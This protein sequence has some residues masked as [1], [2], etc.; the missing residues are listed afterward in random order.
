MVALLLPSYADMNE[1]ELLL[2]AAVAAGLLAV[3]L[4]FRKDSSLEGG[5]LLAAVL[6]GYAAFFFG[7]W[8]F[9][10]PPLM[11]YGEHLLVSHR[12]R[13][14]ELAQPLQSN[15]L[16]VI[17]GL[18]VGFTPSLALAA[19][20]P[21]AKML[22]FRGL[23]TAAAIHLACV[24]YTTRLFVKNQPGD[25]WTR[26]RSV[27]KAVVFVLVPGF[28]L[29]GVNLKSLAL[30][31]AAL[32]LVEL[33]LLGFRYSLGNPANYPNNRQRWLVQGGASLA[34]SMLLWP[35]DHLLRTWT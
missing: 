14:A 22:A 28:A 13:K 21:E 29:S 6:L 19:W 32:L 35:L 17:F 23:V 12:L 5:A 2:R 11:L 27:G 16:W 10:V 31:L 3:V 18:A 26:Q 15:D 33:G 1:P 34:G 9:L 4:S 20:H 25:E 30:G 7:G 8:R 24:H